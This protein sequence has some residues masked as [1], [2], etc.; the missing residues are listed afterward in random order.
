MNSSVY[1]GQA[2][3]LQKAIT[4]NPSFAAKL[5]EG[6]LS[7]AYEAIAAIH[8]ARNWNTLCASEAPV[9]PSVGTASEGEAAYTVEPYL[10]EPLELFG[11]FKRLN[12]LIVLE[13][14]VS[15]SQLGSDL[16]EAFSSGY[17]VSVV[18][19]VSDFQHLA[20][21]MNGVSLSNGDEPELG[22]SMALRTGFLHIDGESPKL[23]AAALALLSK[24]ARAGALLVVKDADRLFGE[25]ASGAT[26]RMATDFNRAGGAV[27]LTTQEEESISAWSALLPRYDVLKHKRLV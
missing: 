8:G 7:A 9:G 1:K 21:A 20:L 22:S 27:L 15:N 14:A 4:A 17:Q 23:S 13:G 18:S 12:P 11:E 2:H 25:D 16:I 3:R 19:R 24:R 26:L 10:P 5:A 6:K